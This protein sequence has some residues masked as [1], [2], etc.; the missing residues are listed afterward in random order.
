[1]LSMS[2]VFS[3]DGS[4]FAAE[5]DLVLADISYVLGMVAWSRVHAGVTKAG[6]LMVAWRRF[7]DDGAVSLQPR[8]I[9]ESMGVCRRI[10]REVTHGWAPVWGARESGGRYPSSHMCV[11]GM[12][13]I[14]QSQIS[15]LMVFNA[16]CVGPA[17]GKKSGSEK[18][19]LGLDRRSQIA[20]SGV[21]FAY[22]RCC[23]QR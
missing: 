14:T 7:H 6:S 23:L 20:G 10:L 8:F 9:A 16:G 19:M 13:Q 5:G 21:I 12:E 15:S 18:R 17:M 1:M 22:L 3:A 4:G 2:V 11:A